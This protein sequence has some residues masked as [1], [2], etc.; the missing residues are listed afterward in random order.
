MSGWSNA[1]HVLSVFSHC[2]SAPGRKRS[3]QREK[4]S[5][6]KT[7]QKRRRTKEKLVSK[8]RR[9]SKETARRKE[10]G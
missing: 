3:K 5:Q 1:R 10:K 8:T 4:T 9:T 6:K 2:R 7:S